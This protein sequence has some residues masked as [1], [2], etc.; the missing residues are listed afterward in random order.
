MASPAVGSRNGNGLTTAGTTFTTSS[1]GSVVGQL[2]IIF[3]RITGAAT[4][5]SVNATGGTGAF[6]EF[7]PAN[8]DASDDTTTCWYRM[9]TGGEAA[10]IT[11]TWT[12]SNKAACTYYAITGAE[13]PGTQP[14]EA[15]AQV[16]TGANADPDPITPTGGSKD[17]LFLVFLAMDG[18]TQTISQAP[19]NYVN[20]IAFNSGTGGSA[21]TNCRVG[22]AERALTAASDD[23]GAFTSDAP[24][25][26]WTAFTV[27]VHPPGTSGNTYTKSGF[28]R[29]SA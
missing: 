20:L 14:P 10:T 6:T 11:A 3:L 28:G 17:Y 16:G 29:E 13:T 25:A 2:Y 22:S 19:T 4:G 1:I 23:P 21:A 26:G 8:N 9:Y 18:E 27:A 7:T 24:G 15:V 5:I 12:G